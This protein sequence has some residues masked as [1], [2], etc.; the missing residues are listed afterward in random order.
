[1]FLEKYGELN[2]MKEIILPKEINEAYYLMNEIKKAFGP[3]AIKN[4]DIAEIK[5]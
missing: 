5:L 3:K 2:A 4:G 1:M